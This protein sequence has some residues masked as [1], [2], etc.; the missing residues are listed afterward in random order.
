MDRIRQGIQLLLEGYRWGA[1]ST[2]AESID[3][4]IAGGMKCPSCGGP[5]YW[6]GYYKP[7][8]YIALAVCYICGKETAF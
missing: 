1:P 5:C 7:G 4:E 8:S 3:Q 2:E 6:E